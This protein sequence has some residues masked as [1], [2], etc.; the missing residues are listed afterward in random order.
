METFL[1]LTVLQW[2]FPN[3][4]ILAL[5]VC[6]ALGAG[7]PSQPLFW[8]SVE[9]KCLVHAFFTYKSTVGVESSSEVLLYFSRRAYVMHVSPW[10]CRAFAANATFVV[11]KKWDKFPFTTSA[12]LSCLKHII[13]VCMEKEPTKLTQ[14][15]LRNAAFTARQW[16]ITVTRWCPFSWRNV[17]SDCIHCFVIYRTALNCICLWYFV[18]F[19]QNGRGWAWIILGTHATVGL[20][21]LGLSFQIQKPRSCHAGKKENKLYKHKFRWTRSSK[22]VVSEANL[23]RVLLSWQL[24]SRP[25]V[26]VMTRMRC[27]SQ[28]DVDCMDWFV[29]ERLLL[30]LT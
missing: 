22:G 1:I 9:Q 26:G 29:I 28:A 13:S 3:V 17:V 24:I 8:E 6:I 5:V 15:W 11:D 4:E 2:L 16:L 27:D 14:I 23:P 21:W 7:F 18:L 20:R 12:A 30:H 25:A 19:Y 10:C